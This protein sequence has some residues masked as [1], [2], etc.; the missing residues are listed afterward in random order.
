[1]KNTRP[2][3]DIGIIAV[4]CV[5]VVMIAVSARA[6]AVT[7]GCTIDQKG[8]PDNGTKFT[9]EIDLAAGVVRIGK[10]TYR[11]DQVTDRYVYYGRGSV[12][13]IPYS[14]YRFDRKTDVVES[15]NIDGVNWFPD[16]NCKSSQG[17]QP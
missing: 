15:S 10:A 5:T 8:N 9:V 16:A 6:E 4:V 13:Q 12:P 14:G 11:T 3:R 1:M 7:L 2:M 17:G